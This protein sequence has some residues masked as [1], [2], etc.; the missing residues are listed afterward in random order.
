MKAKI[1]KYTQR[2]QPRGKN[3]FP[4][5]PP[6]VAINKRIEG[7]HIMSALSGIKRIEPRIH[8]IRLS[9]GYIDYKQLRDKYGWPGLHQM[10]ETENRIEPNYRFCAHITHG[11]NEFSFY[12]G[13][14]EYKFPKCR[15]ST[16][17][18]QPEFLHFLSQI[19]PTAI[20][21]YVEYAI[22]FFC[23]DQDAVADVF[24]IFRR[25][26]WFPR[27]CHTTMAGG[28][29]YGWREPREENAV[30]QVWNK[31]GK[32]VRARLYERGPDDAEQKKDNGAP[33]WDH[34]DCDRVRW[35][36]VMRLNSK[37][38]VKG[39]IR[40]LNDIL[41]NPRFADI[42]EK[43]IQ[44]MKFEKTNVLPRDWEDYNIPDKDGYAECF[45]EVYYFANKCGR[46]NVSQCKV[47]AERFRGL[48]FRLQRE[49][50]NFEENWSKEVA[51]IRGKGYSVAIYNNK[52]T[53]IKFHQNTLYN[54]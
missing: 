44:F 14:K 50:Q 25:Y 17:C 2:C 40:T 7:N 53:N 19:F 38:F 3:H 15:I 22:D 12:T 46:V 48:K 20:L 6:S 32:Y 10:G 33:Y 16:S 47:E 34:S 42:V 41:D 31:H 5:E 39:G 1:Q 18:S 36:K 9:N 35:E 26:L 54:G 4:S 8:R 21:A 52:I 28:T 49:F 27:S 43:E 29:F 23:K 37:P 45:Q 30:Q 13:R 51:Q 11:K 24:C